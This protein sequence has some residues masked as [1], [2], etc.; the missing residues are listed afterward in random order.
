MLLN[1]FLVMVHPL[2]H[3]QVEGS[4][5]IHMLIEERYLPTPIC[6]LHGLE[7]FRFCKDTLNQ[8]GINIDQ[9]YLKQM[10]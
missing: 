5:G 4:I 8:R 2:V 9:A 6:R 1:G 7:M 10:E 3:I